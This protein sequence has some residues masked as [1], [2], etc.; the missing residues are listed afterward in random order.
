MFL[1]DVLEKKYN[2]TYQNVYNDLKQ[3]KENDPSFTIEKLK[4][5]LNTLYINQGNDW[6]GKGEVKNI[7]TSATI[8]AC[9]TL[10][11]EWKEEYS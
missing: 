5:L 8:S 3:Q 11:A 6:L 9:E 10:L 2:T 7:T 4:E 1:D